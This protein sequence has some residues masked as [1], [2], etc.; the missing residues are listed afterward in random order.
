MRQK[1]QKKM[2]EASAKREAQLKKSAPTLFKKYP[3]LYDDFGGPDMIDDWE[4]FELVV[5]RYR[6]GNFERLW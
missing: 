4:M 2:A 6:N 5:D 1:F 3:Q